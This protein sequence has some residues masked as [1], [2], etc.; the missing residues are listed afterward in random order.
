MEDSEVKMNK[1]RHCG[2]SHDRQDDAE[3]DRY[4]EK[5]HGRALMP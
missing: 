2:P 4:R 3:N 5:Y 1:T